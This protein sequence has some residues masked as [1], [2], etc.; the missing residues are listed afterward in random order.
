VEQVIFL[1]VLH[2]LFISGSDRSC[3]RCDT[4][5]SPLHQRPDGR[6]VLLDQSELVLSSLDLVFFDTTSLYFEGAGGQ[7]IGK[8]GLSK[9]H[10]PDLN[11]LRDSKT[12]FMWDNPALWLTAA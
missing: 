12:V 3:K 8:R 4:V 9:D 6:T 10:R 11:F 1:T 2:H 5:C 7:E